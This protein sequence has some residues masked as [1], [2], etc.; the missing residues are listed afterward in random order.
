MILIGDLYQLPPVTTYSEDKLFK[1]HYESPYFFSAKVFEKNPAKIPFCMEFTELE[2]VYRQKDKDFINLLNS[3]RNN[4]IIEKELHLINQ[5]FNPDFK[6]ADD[7]FYIYLTTTNNLSSEINE[8]KLDKVKGKLYHYYGRIFG[9]FNNEALPTEIDLR[10][11]IGAQVM[12]LNNDSKGRWVN[13]T[14]G[15]IVKIEKDPNFNGDIIWVELTTGEIESVLPYTWKLFHYE[16]NSRSGVIETEEMG[17]FTQYP[18][19]LAWS[20]TIHKSQ[21]KTFDKVIIDIGRG[22]FAHGQMYVAMSRCTSLEGIILKQPLQKKHIWMDWR[23]VKF[24][25]EYQYKQA[26]ERCSL[27]E[28][29]GIIQDAI[30]NKTKLSIV[31]LKPDDTKSKRI[32]LPKFLGDLEYQN[33]KFLGLE[34]FCFQRKEDRVFKLNRILEIKETD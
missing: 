15:K 21:G 1:E 30:K 5:R 17:S 24:I 28:K 6:I 34:A 3:I 29:T 18:L 16:F 9:N 31:Y 23:V 10:L 13:G 27:D 14:I 33:K 22:T 8:T 11:K 12:L 20:V 4:T 2:K 25:T 32:I 7:S 26:D 19:K